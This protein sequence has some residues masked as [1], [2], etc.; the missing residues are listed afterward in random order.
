VQAIKGYCDMWGIAGVKNPGVDM[1]C[2]RVTPGGARG[3]C[4]HPSPIARNPLLGLGLRLWWRFSRHAGAKCAI[5][6]GK[7]TLSPM[8]RPLPLFDYCPLSPV[9][10][11]ARAQK[12]P[13]RSLSPGRVCVGRSYPT[14][15]TPLPLSSPTIL[16]TPGGNSVGLWAFRLSILHPPGR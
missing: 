15:S 5:F 14:Y 2:I 13:P 6:P 11:P 12:N 4:F 9:F 1:T 8:H 3:V 7:T 10:V 16:A